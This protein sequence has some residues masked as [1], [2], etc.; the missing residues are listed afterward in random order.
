MA[1]F[2][3]SQSWTGPFPHTRFSAW[4]QAEMKD[5]LL[6]ARRLLGS[7]VTFAE[8]SSREQVLALFYTWLELL[9]PQRDFLRKLEKIQPW[10]KTASLWDGVKPVFLAWTK[11]L[12]DQGLEARDIARRPFLPDYYPQLLWADAMVV[13]S[14]WLYDPTED[15]SRTDALVEK[16]VNFLFDL[17]QPNALDSGW[18]LVSFVLRRK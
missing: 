5:L 2:L 14:Q 11:E 7:D 8:Y 13:M 16:S 18:D 9:G 4:E 3:Q 17:L 6:E 1:A 12:I 15:L 10:T